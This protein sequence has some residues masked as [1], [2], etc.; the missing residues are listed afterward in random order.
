MPERRVLSVHRY[1][2]TYSVGATAATSSFVYDK[3]GRV[4]SQIRV[5]SS[6]ARHDRSTIA[7]GNAISSTSRRGL[8]TTMSYDALGRVVAR[9]TPRV[10]FPRVLCAICHNEVGTQFPQYKYDYDSVHAPGLHRPDSRGGTVDGTC[11][12]DRAHSLRVRRSRPHGASGQSF[13]RVRRGYYPNGA[14]KA[15]TSWT[16]DIRHRGVHALANREAI[17]PELSAYD[18]SG[19]RVE[20]LDHQGGRQ[21]YGYDAVGQMERTTDRAA[22]GGDTVRVTFGYD[23]RG[24]S[25]RSPPR[26]RDRSPRGATTTRGAQRPVPRRGSLTRSRYMMRA[27]SACT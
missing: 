8:T 11:D 2:S 25:R 3:A 21:T 14:F 23:A 19:R 12:P 9:V 10:S 24:H 26:S 6:G 27:G 15:D 7:A 16:R 5:G 4:T 17:D 13:A 18:L 20:R 1:S 22:L